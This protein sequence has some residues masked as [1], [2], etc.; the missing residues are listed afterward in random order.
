MTG[1]EFAEDLI[2]K[3]RVIVVPGDGFGDEGKKYVRL[4]FATSEERIREGIRR[5]GKYMEERSK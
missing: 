4:V 1:G 5:I 3:A 2:E